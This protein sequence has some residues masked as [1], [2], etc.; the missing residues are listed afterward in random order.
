MDRAIQMIIAVASLVTAAGTV[1][2]HE[3]RRVFGLDGS[4]A[5]CEKKVREGQALDD[6]DLSG[7]DAFELSLCRNT[8]YAKH[9]RLF[10]KAVYRDYFLKQGYKVN[11]RYHD[12]HLSSVDRA[13]VARI[14]AAEKRAKP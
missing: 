1:A 11:P 7:V 14:V 9:G 12:S 6:Q 3:T 5:R 8:V 10:Q 4:L 2:S 13:N